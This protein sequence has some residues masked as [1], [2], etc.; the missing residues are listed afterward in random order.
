LFL[1][2]SLVPEGQFL[3]C[4]PS[5]YTS[6]KQY[7]L[8][9]V[10]FNFNSTRLLLKLV[11]ALTRQVLKRYLIGSFSNE[12]GPT[13]HIDQKVNESQNNKKSKTQHIW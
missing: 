11:P 8:F 10:W 3:P 4:P 7:W 12:L 2:N 13:K 9:K 1:A 5:S 6:E